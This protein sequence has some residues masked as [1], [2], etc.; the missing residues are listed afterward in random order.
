LLRDKLLERD[1]SRFSWCI[2]PAD[3]DSY[4]EGVGLKL[5]SVTT[6]QQLQS[7]FR[8]APERLK[9]ERVSGEHVYIAQ[10]PA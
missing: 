9:L 6:Y 1:R 8:S 7:A 3:V 4:L 10:G 5:H 2:A